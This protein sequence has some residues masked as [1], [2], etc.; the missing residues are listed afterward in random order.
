MS[1]MLPHMPLQIG[2]SSKMMK[3]QIADLTTAMDLMQK[4]EQIGLENKFFYD[5][6]RKMWREEGKE[7]PQEAAPPPPPPIVPHFQNGLTP[8]AP[9]AEPPP[10]LGP[11]LTAGSGRSS[12]GALPPI[13]APPSGP[14]SASRA[15][16]RSRYVDPM[17]PE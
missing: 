2:M 8:A 3:S 14:A 7:I 17:N 15:G 1:G 12:S 6:E 9:P 16:P 4:E 10:G 5:K 11:E 13:P